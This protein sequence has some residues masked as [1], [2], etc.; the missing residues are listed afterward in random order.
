MTK[1]LNIIKLKKVW[2]TALILIVV[3]FIFVSRVSN[4]SLYTAVYTV[5][6]QDVRQTVLATGTVTSQSNLNLSFKNSGNLQNLNVAVGNKVRTGQVLAMLDEKDAAASIKQ[7]TAAVVSAQ[8]NYDKVVNGASSAQVQVAQVAVN[9]AQVALNNTISQQQ[10]AVSNAYS[11]MLNSGLS[12]TSTLSDSTSASL[13]LSGTYTGTAQGSYNLSLSS[14]SGGA[15]LSYSGL[16]NGSINVVRGV[17]AALGTKGL[18]VTF[19]STGS[20]NSGDTWVVNVPN[21][22]ASTYLTNYNAYQTALQTQ[23]QLVSTAQANLDQAKAQ[24]NLQTTAARPEDVNAALGALESAQAQL[25]IAQNTY[26]NNEIIAPIDGTITSVDAKIGEQITSQKEILVLLDENSLHVESD[27]SES[28]IA[29]VQSGQAIDMTMD[30][31]GPDK[32]FSGSVISI[33][34]ASTVVSGV[35]DFR[36][37]SSLP[38]DPAIKP[39]MTVNLTITV[40]DKPNTLA[41]PSRLIKTKNNQN[42]VTVFNSDNKTVKDV[43]IGIGL[44]GDSYTEVTSG[45][46]SGDVLASLKTK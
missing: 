19:G 24:L 46:S 10:T 38:N 17:P 11:T 14:S 45:L 21:T 42:Y 18:F 34:P 37:I 8:A 28:S 7:A 2:V 23:T 20:L 12:A 6:P 32:H 4:S 35:I 30:A 44:E 26:S 31:F 33:D 40:A 27:I 36:V 25:Q 39:G 13:T 9:S 5:A 43:P 22:Q 41:V 3:I 1:F 15:V 16:E 29:E